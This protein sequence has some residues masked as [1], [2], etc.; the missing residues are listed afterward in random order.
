MQFDLLFYSFNQTTFGLIL[1]RENPRPQGKLGFPGFPPIT[2]IDGVNFGYHIRHLLHLN[3]TDLL[4][5]TGEL[6]GKPLPPQLLNYPNETSAKQQENN[7]K[8]KL[9]EGQ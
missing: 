3:N 6:T 1:E 4:D 8:I 9:T 2:E 5:M 7:D